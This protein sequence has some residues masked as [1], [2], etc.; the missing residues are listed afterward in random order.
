MTTRNV[1]LLISDG[2]FAWG[3]GPR[4][5]GTTR[6]FDHL[7]GAVPEALPRGQASI[8][9]QAGGQNPQ[10]LIDPANSLMFLAN[11]SDDRFNRT[12]RAVLA[13]DVHPLTAIRWRPSG[14][15]RPVPAFAGG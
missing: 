1:F 6:P 12:A 11:R 9:P 13:P 15:V 7:A 2:A 10:S 5:P 14:D 4:D 3:P 8:P